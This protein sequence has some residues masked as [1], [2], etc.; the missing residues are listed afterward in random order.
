LHI[1]QCHTEH[2]YPKLKGT[3]V[4]LNLKLQITVLV[5]QRRQTGIIFAAKLHKNKQTNSKTFSLDLPHAFSFRQFSIVNILKTG[6]VTYGATTCFFISS[7][8]IY[9]FL[10]SSNVCLNP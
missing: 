4:I 3:W 5:V 8:S 1:F 9:L 10:S 2:Y 7:F 6:T